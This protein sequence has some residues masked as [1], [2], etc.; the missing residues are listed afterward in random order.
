MGTVLGEVLGGQADKHFNQWLDGSYTDE[1]GVNADVEKCSRDAALKAL[2]FLVKKASEHTDLNDTEKHHLSHLFK[3]ARKKLKEI[4]SL[5]EN[6]PGLAQNPLTEL[7]E[8]SRIL[9]GDAS[10][11]EAQL[12]A[13]LVRYVLRLAGLN[14]ETNLLY[15]TGCKTACPCATARNGCIGLRSIALPLPTT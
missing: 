5:P 9:N 15:A 3:G 11:K 14:H 10:V 1:I 2:L 4:E 13:H 7:R 6:D 12:N 8:I